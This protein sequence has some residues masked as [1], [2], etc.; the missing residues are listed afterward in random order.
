MHLAKIAASTQVFAVVVGSQ[1]VPGPVPQTTSNWRFRHCR[2]NRRRIG[3]G[4][5]A[6]LIE[7][8]GLVDPK[9]AGAHV[10]HAAVGTLDLAMAAQG[11]AVVLDGAF[12]GIGV[13]RYVT[14][15]PAVPRIFAPARLATGT[16]ICGVG[17]A[18]CGVAGWWFLYRLSLRSDRRY[19]SIHAKCRRTSKAL[20]AGALALGVDVIVAARHARNH[21]FAT[22]MAPVGPGIRRRTTVVADVAFAVSERVDAIVDPLLALV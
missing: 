12:W 13:H 15:P 22:I 8:G 14:G 19:R 10:V 17:H 2:R 5:L 6:P 21:R 3:T 7:R 20:V 1:A 18:R 11:C 9:A 16:A 4:V